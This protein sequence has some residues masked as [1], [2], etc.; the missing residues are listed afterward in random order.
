MSLCSSEAERERTNWASA[1]EI[2]VA[3]DISDDE[4]DAVS[5][6]DDGREESEG[7]G[8]V[9]GEDRDGE[10]TPIPSKRFRSSATSRSRA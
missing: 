5:G 9:G 10:C 3:V 1:R 2:A 7:T 4:A 6:G 8:D